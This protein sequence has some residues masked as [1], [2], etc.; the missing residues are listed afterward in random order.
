MCHDLGTC[1]CGASILPVQSAQILKKQ[2]DMRQR[3]PKVEKRTLVIRN[4]YMIHGGKNKLICKNLQSK[5][6]R[7]KQT[8]KKKEEKKGGHPEEAKVYASSPHLHV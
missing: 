6:W 5:T 4:A 1:T 7:Q 8:E 2:W 3:V